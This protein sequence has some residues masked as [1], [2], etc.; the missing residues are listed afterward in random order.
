MRRKKRVIN[1]NSDEDGRVVQIVRSMSERKILEA[2]SFKTSLYRKPIP[3]PL[4]RRILIQ[5]KMTCVCKAGPNGGPCMEEFTV[6]DEIE[7]NHHSPPLADRKFDLYEMDFIPP[8][9]DPNY[10]R[11]EKKAHHSIHT[12][13]TAATTRGSVVGE[14]ARA[15]AIRGAQRTHQQV[16]SEKA[17]GAAVEVDVK[18]SEAAVAQRDRKER[19]QISRATVADTGA[20]GAST[21]ITEKIQAAINDKDRIRNEREQRKAGSSWP[22]GRKLQGGGFQKK[23]KNRLAKPDFSGGGDPDAVEDDV[24]SAEHQTSLFCLSNRELRSRSPALICAEVM[25]EC[26]SVTYR[27]GSPSRL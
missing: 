15:K 2:G 20:S 5:Q 16:M 10:I 14:N 1:V 24:H 4:K 12:H 23:I 21:A 17:G 27:S 8:Q 25:S 26:M 9:L 13:G 22:Q 11:A 6:D 3:E 7:F 19:Q 18:V